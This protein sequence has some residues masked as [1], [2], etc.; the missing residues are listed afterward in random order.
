MD[1][2]GAAQEVVHPTAITSL[3]L[4]ALI[5]VLGPIVSRLLH[6]YI[7]DV[8]IL[9]LLGAIIGPNALAWAGTGGGVDLLSELGLGMLFLLAGYE[10]DPK[11]LRGKP[12]RTAWLVWAGCLIFAFL[13]VSAAVLLDSG[14]ETGFTAKVAVAIAMT[15]TALGTL[16]P[17]VKQA[18]FLDQPLGQAVLAHGAVGEL[19]PIVAMSVLLTSRSPLAAVVVLLIFAVAAA[20]IGFVPQRV[21]Q[22]SPWLGRALRGMGGGTAQLPVRGVFLL[23]LVLMAVAETFDLDVVLGA[24]AAGVVLRGMITD[25]HPEVD[26]ALEAIGFGLLIPVFF[27]VSGMGIDISAVLSHPVLWASFVLSI[28]IARGLPVWLSERYVPHGANLPTARERA[29]LALYAATGLPIIVAVTQVATGSGLMGADLASVL[30]AAGAT[31]VLL[32]PLLA[33][34]IGER[35]LS[36]VEPRV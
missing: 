17:I 11:L 19:A 2:L 10:L 27:V 5:A 3:F 26:S 34:V 24:F 30:V 21:F 29:Q 32:F 15:S 1:L 23:L 25:A 28:A 31:T 9:L 33:R 7:P 22:K 4:I 8:V 36:T 6:G 12:G 16:L 35:E 13:L 14:A 18:G 20:W